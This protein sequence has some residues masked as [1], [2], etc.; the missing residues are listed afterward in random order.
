MLGKTP[1]QWE[2][3]LDS[4]PFRNY[5]SVYVVE[6]TN[7]PKQYY[8]LVDLHSDSVVWH[9]GEKHSRE[10]AEKVAKEFAA[11][12]ITKLYDKVFG[13]DWHKSMEFDRYW[14]DIYKEGHGKK[15]KK[16]K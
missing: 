11:T 10:N 14:K 15:Q 6:H 9:L 12:P 4:S 8:V 13:G 5:G 2:K 1:K 3:M 16:A 7:R